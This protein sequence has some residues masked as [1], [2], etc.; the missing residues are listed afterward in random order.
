MI[1][2]KDSDG[3]SSIGAA[4]ADAGRAIAVGGGRI[5]V[6]AAIS[7]LPLSWQQDI[8]HFIVPVWFW[9]VPPWCS[10]SMGASAGLDC[11]AAA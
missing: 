1:D 5:K 4:V 6:T 3:L 9:L 7:E 10:H 8:E 2:C 11:P